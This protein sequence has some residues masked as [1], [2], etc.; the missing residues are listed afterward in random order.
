V[1]GGI[2]KLSGNSRKAR[3]GGDKK[4]LSG[5]TKITFAPRVETAT[6]SSTTTSSSTTPTPTNP[7]HQHHH[8][9][10]DHL[11]PEQTPED[12]PGD[13]RDSQKNIGEP[14]AAQMDPL[15]QHASKEDD[16][17]HEEEEE[18]EEEKEQAAAAAGAGLTSQQQQQ[19]RK[20]KGH[21][22]SRSVGTFIPSLSLNPFLR[23][24][25]DDAGGGKVDHG[26]SFPS[27]L[28]PRRIIASR[29]RDRELE[30][31]KEK[32]EKE[33][34]TFL[35]HNYGILASPHDK[36]RP[37]AADDPDDARRRVF[38]VPLRTLLQRDGTPLPRLAADAISALHREGK[39]PFQYPPPLIIYS[40][41]PSFCKRPPSRTHH[42]MSTM[43]AC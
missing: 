21:S 2:L 3:K 10:H 29:D 25:E 40:P 36:K 34:R 1:V 24:D 41:P 33:L 6:A 30:R 7:H 23:R 9:R 18:K 27:L 31:E 14:V 43:R 28:S 15:G 8:R 11:D 13:T 19:Q 17:D 42:H 35:G 38:H 32:R 26:R 20:G 16:D 22:R 5:G 4:P 39:Q 37:A 12:G